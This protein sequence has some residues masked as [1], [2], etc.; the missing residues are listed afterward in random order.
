EIIW[1]YKSGGSSKR[2]FSRKHDNIIV[3]SKTEGYDFF[4]LME[5]SYNRGLK[6]YHF[7]GVKEYQDETGWYT[8]VRMKDVWDLNMVGRTSGERTGY[9]TQKP[10]K[11][12]ERMVE[13]STKPG[14]ICAD[15]YCGSG[16]LAVAAAYLGRKFAVCDANPVAAGITADRIA[17]ENKRFS[18]A[19]SS[20]TANSA[21]GVFP[22]GSAVIPGTDL[23]IR[24]EKISEGCA[25][26]RFIEEKGRD[27]GSQLD[28]VTD[29]DRLDKGSRDV[30]LSCVENDP[31]ELIKSWSAGKLDENGVFSPEEIFSRNGKKLSRE[32]IV[33]IPPDFREGSEDQR[34]DV[35]EAGVASPVVKV[36][37][38]LGRDFYIEM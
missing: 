8:N 7:K 26:V 10:L 15:F 3:Y 32:G 17:A 22:P 30:F 6:P 34:K 16:T 24:T 28:Y 1:T 37:D 31:F 25:V 21:L 20:Y 18:L 5:K 4:P 36:T 35:A 9:A 2:R 29:M 19:A 27:E 13:C 12:I 33:D 38:I 14:D 11:L 23:F